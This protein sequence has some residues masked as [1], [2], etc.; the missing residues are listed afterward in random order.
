MHDGE[1]VVEQGPADVVNRDRVPHRQLNGV[2][3]LSAPEALADRPVLFAEP[4][5]T[6]PFR[7][8]EQS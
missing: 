7:V 2:A 3:M 6:R 5:L 1:I 4:E 8:G